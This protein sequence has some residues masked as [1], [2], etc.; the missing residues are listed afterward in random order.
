MYA[1]LRCL[2]ALLFITNCAYSQAAQWLTPLSARQQPANEHL[3]KVDSHLLQQAVQNTGKSVTQSRY[4]ALPDESGQLHDWQLHPLHHF[5]PQLAARFPAI[6]SFRLTSPHH[7]GLSGV[8]SLSP[9]G[10]NAL[11]Q[12]SSK[13]SA[14]RWLELTPVANG[15][16]L[17]KRQYMP[18]SVSAGND[19]LPLPFAHKST[20]LNSKKPTSG[21]EIRTYR[22]ALTASGEY[23][24]FH[25]GTVA[26]V[27]AQYNVLLGR[28]NLILLQDLAIQMQL[29][30]NNDLLI[31]L[32]PQQDPFTNTDAVDDLAAN[33]QWVDD[34]I[35][36][37]NY[38]IG[39]LLNT[40]GG[41]L[42]Y[43]NS[44]CSANFKAQGYTG[45]PSPTGDSFY[46]DLFLHELGHQLGASHTFNALGEGACTASQRSGNE[47]VE[48]GSGSTIMSYAGICETQDLQ[49]N[50]DPYYH[51]ASIQKIRDDLADKQASCGFVNADGAQPTTPPTLTTA[52]TSYTIPAL[53]PFR[54]QVSGSDSDGDS[55][56]YTIEQMNS[57]GGSGGTAN[58]QEMQQDN[59]LNPLFRST[60]PQQ[61]SAHFFPPI[62]SLRT[63]N[64]A[65]GEV[66]PERARLLRFRA[67]VRDGKGG[68]NQLDLSLQVQG[69]NRGFEFI[70]PVRQVSWPGKSQ[71]QIEWFTANT[72]ADSDSAASC[73][74]LN[75]TLDIDGSNH[76]A[77][78]LG[79]LDN[80][81]SGT[82]TLPNVDSS[83]ARIMLACANN[84]FFTITPADIRIERQNTAPVATNDS[85]TVRQDASAS[86]FDILANDSDEDGD[87]LSLQSL[88]YR[89]NGQAR[90][91]NNQLSYTPA[92]GFSG[93][94]SL[95][96]IVSDGQGGTATAQVNISVTPTPAN[97]SGG[98]LYWL[99]VS[100][101]GICVFIRR[102]SI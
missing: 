24:Q 72:E 21:E 88:D 46:I 81:G 35:G 27:L 29:V 62:A 64:L 60:P 89:G 4:L 20:S 90:I 36:S 32:D 22:L 85:L 41:G 101:L 80:T 51:A 75:V 84:V 15:L 73:P 63:Q 14:Q 30:A 44:L 11:Y 5:A 61:Q 77:T 57:G 87:S 65:K 45:S 54:L 13:P 39:H 40:N 48:P 71:Q 17:S 19:Q 12:A 3:F 28:I 34:N 91:V 86:Q 7:P 98:S 59:G 31:F 53:T 18:R 74:T 50:S 102:R 100:W 67:S 82:I 56:L 6:Q 38:D 8:L 47:S 97:N 16:R 9:Q 68:V 83:N 37:G 92:T 99:W 49:L 96:Y 69:N 26:S 42:A 76:F 33:Q 70:T 2:V 78:D 66:L 25:G 52:Q 58:L 23:S 10:V 43:V 55:L 95:S 94:D 79:Q 1:T 93:Q